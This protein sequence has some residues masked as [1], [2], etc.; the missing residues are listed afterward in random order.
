MFGPNLKSLV[1]MEQVVEEEHKGYA[2]EDEQGHLYAG[3][4]VDFGHDVAGGDVDGN[5]GGDGQADIDRVPGESH[6]ENAGECSAPEQGGGTPGFHATAAAG[7]H[8]R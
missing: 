1:Q 7:E 6:K 5:A 4:V 3:F 2:D 8:D